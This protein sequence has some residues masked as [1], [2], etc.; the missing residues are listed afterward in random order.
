[1]IKQLEHII[2]RVISDAVRIDGNAHPDELQVAKQLLDDWRQIEFHG[3][4]IDF[5]AW[6]IFQDQFKED[7]D[8]LIT[9]RELEAF[10]EKYKK[11]LPEN[12]GNDLVEACYRI[13]SATSQ[14]NKA[15]LVF[16]SK[17]RSIVEK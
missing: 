1:M 17:I 14:R 2:G 7:Q 8:E 5:N 12:F 13:A 15:E 11:D 6:Y 10:M 9:Y 3:E 4:L 16:M